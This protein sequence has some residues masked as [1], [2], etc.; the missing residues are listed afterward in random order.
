MDDGVC[1]TSITEP[2]TAVARLTPQP[3]DE[4]SS[5]GSPSGAARRRSVCSNPV[6]SP[7]ASNRTLSP[8][9]GSARSGRGSWQ[10]HRRRESLVDSEADGMA[11]KQPD[12]LD[13]SAAADDRKG[14]DP[15]AKSTVPRL[16][17][18]RGSYTKPHTRRA[19]NGQRS[20]LLPGDSTSDVSPKALRKLPRAN[21][22]QSVRSTDDSDHVTDSQG[23]NPR[24]KSQQTNPLLAGLMS[25]DGSGAGSKRGSTESVVER[26]RS[27]AVNGRSSSH[28]TRTSPSRRQSNRM[29]IS[30]MWLP[31]ADADKSTASVSLADEN[32]ALR[33]QVAALQDEVSAKNTLLEQKASESAQLNRQLFELRQEMEFYKIDHAFGAWKSTPGSVPIQ[34]GKSAGQASSSQIP[35]VSKRE[36]AER[37]D[38]QI[39]AED[40]RAELPTISTSAV[41]VADAEIPVASSVRSIAPA[42]AAGHVSNQRQTQ[43]DHAGF[44]PFSRPSDADIEAAFNKEASRSLVAADSTLDDLRLKYVQLGI[45]GC[46][47]ILSC[48]CTVV[49][50][51]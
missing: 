49:F 42:S 18:I 48:S 30:A 10:L 25:A 17:P 38:E 9:G 33:L 28:S 2:H 16:S 47:H 24:R 4:L 44:E 36:E 26:R 23:A 20:A 3:G 21:S 41:A 32:A 51:L 19:S 39:R 7:R 37:S 27:F 1:A 13:D 22:Q 34:Q 43:S 31:T 12:A 45:H 29:S 35:S 40:I 5:V 50:Q 8:S 6:K 11:D 14:S 15:E 46:F